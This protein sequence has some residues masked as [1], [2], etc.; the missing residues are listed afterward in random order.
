MF[1]ILAAT[2]A[3]SLIYLFVLKPLKYWREKNVPQKPILDILQMFISGLIFGKPFAEIVD[4]L[5]NE[6]PQKRYLF[7]LF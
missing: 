4:K 2:L 1:W 3:A 6:F 7:Q 5:Y